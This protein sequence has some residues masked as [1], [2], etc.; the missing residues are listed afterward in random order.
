MN[1]QGLPER[2]L[3]ARPRLYALKRF[4]IEEILWGWLLCGLLRLAPN[5]LPDLRAR[6]DGQRVLVAACGPGDAS[7]PLAGAG[8]VTAFDASAR[9]AGACRARHPGW[10]V[11]CADLLRIPHGDRAFDVSVLYSTLHHFPAGAR[12]ALAELRRVTR[13]RI[14]LLEG[15]VPE[16]G[17][18]RA[19]LLLWYRLVDGGHH[20]YTRDELVSAIQELGLRIERSWRCGP[21][22]HLWLAELVR[23]DAAAG[24]TSCGTGDSGEA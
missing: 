18:P 1:E 10:H 12:A 2:I 5:P 3:F 16:Q 4:V 14:V 6:F 13:G 19:L 20:Y 17:L 24:S 9:F 22:R 21:I 23:D 15:V 8:R 11:Y 7:P